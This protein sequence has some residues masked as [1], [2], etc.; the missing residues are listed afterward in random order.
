M[1]PITV[2]RQFVKNGWTIAN[3][4]AII[5]QIGKSNFDEIT[6]LAQKQA[7]RVIFSDLVMRRVFCVQKK[8]LQ[9]KKL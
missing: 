5:S 3:R 7:E 9:Q 6:L 4:K 2:L 1:A 8:Y